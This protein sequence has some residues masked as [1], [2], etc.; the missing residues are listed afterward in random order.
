LLRNKA[1][2]VETPVV[3][4]RR[5]HGE[6]KLT[7]RD[8]VEFLA[9][10]VKLRIRRSEEF[11]KFILVGLSG[12]FVNLGFYLLFERKIGLSFALACLLA[13]EL[14]ILS[15]FLPNNAWTFRSRRT[16]FSWRT[17]LLRFHAVAGLAGVADYCT[18]LTLVSGFHVSDVLT[19]LAGL[20]VG[21]FINYLI[22][23]VWTWHELTPA[24]GQDRGV[25]GSRKGPP[26]E[27]L[28]P[29]WVLDD[30]QVK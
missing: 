8:Q 9:N 19:G 20:L 24:Q 23:S 3:F 30:G 25:P 4:H 12:V 26:V 11:I 10:V 15:N 7:L 5:A 14:S 21:V 16:G 13:I 29:A 1:K 17:R 22:N 18:F 28:P 6:S 2:V 27:A